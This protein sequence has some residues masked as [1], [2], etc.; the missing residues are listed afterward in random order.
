MSF[1]IAYVPQVEVVNEVE[2]VTNVS[3]VDVVDEVKKVNLVD[4]VTVVDSVTR[5][6]SVGP[7]DE[8]KKL[9]WPYFPLKTRNYQEGGMIY[10]SPAQSKYQ[11]IFYTNVPV[12]FKGIN[13]CFTAYN[14]EDTYD[15]L[16]GSQY[17]IKGSH[18]KE[19]S[20]NRRLEVYELV[21]ANIPITID[22]YNNSGS[23]KYLLFDFITLSNTAIQENIIH[24]WTF[25][26]NGDNSQVDP[27]DFCTLLVIQPSYVNP[28]SIIETFFLNLI[29][30]STQLPIASISCDEGGGITS[31]Y[32][33]TD[34]ELQ[35]YGFLARANIIAVTSVERQNRVIKIV[36]KNIGSVPHP[37]EIGISGAVH[38]VGV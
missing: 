18:V 5:V 32:I 3:S 36:F 15:V 7:V 17:V 28:D 13:I 37:I 1:V 35:P 29:D 6:D 12:E 26:W 4:K 16:V 8:I 30:L 31:G 22:F 21:D 38:N 24:D 23:E 27:G 10:I 33:E 19:M 20:E 14:I 25:A 9:P 34:P 11:A 2:E